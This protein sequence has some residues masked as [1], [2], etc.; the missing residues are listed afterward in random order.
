MSG[1]EN[2]FCYVEIHVVVTNYDTNDRYT[3]LH[4]SAI[5]ESLQTYIREVKGLFQNTTH[6]ER[7]VP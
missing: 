6:S 7:I 1:C 4:T 2:L 3:A 5:Q